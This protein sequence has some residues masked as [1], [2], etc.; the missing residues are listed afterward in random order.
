MRTIARALIALLALT[1]A[2]VAQFSAPPTI[3]ALPDTSRIST[4]SISGT[5]C[6]C[7][8]TF[9]LYA[10][11]GSQDVDNW[12]QVF[13]G[14]TR[15][16]STDPVF[17]WAIT[18]PTG[19]LSTIARPITDAILTFKQARTGQVTIVGAQ[20]PRR[21]SEFSEA[22]GVPARDH[23]Q[24]LNTLFAE[25]REA[26]DK[27]NRAI[28]GQP[29]ETL[30]LL[31]PAASRAGGVLAFD[32]SGQ[33]V[34]QPNVPAGSIPSN[35]ITNALL[36][37]MPADT[38]KCNP[39]GSTANAQDCTVAQAAAI[40]GFRVP[41][42]ATTTFYVN[43]SGSVSSPCGAFTCSP[44]NDAN[45][46]ATITTPCL[47]IQ[48]TVAYIANAFDFAG[49]AVNVQLADGT[50]NECVVLPPYV[51]T[52]PADKN[53]VIVGDTTVANVVVNCASGQTF[54]AVNVPQGW[55]I[56]NVT[57]KASNACLYADYHSALYWDGGAFN[58]CVANDVQAVNS[59]AFIEFINHNYTTTTSKTCHVSAID[60]AEI[61]WQSVTLTI[62]GSPTFSTGL[63]C[64]KNGGIIDDQFL[65]ISG[66]FTGPTYLLAG[67]PLIF[68]SG[69][70]A[71]TSNSTQYIGMG[72]ISSTEVN[73]YT[74]A[75]PTNKIVG[76]VVNTTAAPGAGQTFV[77]TLRLGG[78]ATALTCT[79]SG[80]VATSCSDYVHATVAIVTTNV[81]DL[82]V[83][84]SAGAAT[85][86][87][88]ASAVMQ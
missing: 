12:V 36:A 58:A 67:R 85:A 22:R 5:T 53:V 4:Y 57:A 73:Y 42:T 43:A 40:L 39:T 9:Q 35:S 71:S 41:L 82:Q 65:T 84:S 27:L 25:G 75:V 62:T 8:I 47:T 1:V 24:V 26:W 68:S 66:S 3:P 34:L 10:D 31:P 79:I 54:T 60:G 56:K 86:V 81:A 76:L 45:N 78:G 37:Q 14:S 6:A 72:S 87:M 15:Y 30:N 16:L 61:I 88:S 49:Q 28:I 7:S 48:H 13:I 33:P 19:S 77:F 52:N 23:N 18:S 64:S 32:G 59:G 51:T 29:G 74:L 17:G 38:V 70:T 2:A 46:C 69:A 20:R 55:V 11:N 44:G 80:A 83:V 21:L 50:Y 63:E